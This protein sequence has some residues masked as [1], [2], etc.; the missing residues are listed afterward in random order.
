MPRKPF[1]PGRLRTRF[2]LEQCSSAPDQYGGSVE[3]WTHV[4]FVWGGV[5]TTRPSAPVRAGGEEP[6]LARTVVLRADPRIEPA[7]RLV[8]GAQ[9]HIIRTVHDPDMTGRF[10]ECRVDTQVP[11]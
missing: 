10:L 7:M 6:A 8:A 1:D 11:A 5:E 4:A 9:R 3:S 2:A